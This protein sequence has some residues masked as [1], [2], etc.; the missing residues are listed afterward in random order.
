MKRPGAPAMSS[1]PCAERRIPSAYTAVAYTPLRPVPYSYLGVHEP[2]Q[3]RLPWAYTSVS[4]GWPRRVSAG[5][6]Q[7]KP[8]TSFKSK[9]AEIQRQFLAR[10]RAT[11]KERIQLKIEVC[12]SMPRRACFFSTSPPLL[13]VCLRVRLWPER[14]VNRICMALPGP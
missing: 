9:L 8:R 1:E 3:G 4:T 7:V 14:T 2:G 5:A 10:Q 12:A 13:F 11:K 6:V